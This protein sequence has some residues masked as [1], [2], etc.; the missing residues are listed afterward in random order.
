MLKTTKLAL[1][2]WSTVTVTHSLTGKLNFDLNV[3]VVMFWH[4]AHIQSTSGEHLYYHISEFSLGLF[5]KA[6]CTLGPLMCPL[7]LP[8]NQ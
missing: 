3:F 8:Q 6:L 4:D 1:L 5:Q 2:L 7:G